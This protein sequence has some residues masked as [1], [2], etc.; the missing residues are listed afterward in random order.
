MYETVEGTFQWMNQIPKGNLLEF[1]VFSGNTMN[2]LIKGAE[3]SGQ[4]FEAVYGF[5]SW[6]GLP[7]ETEGVWQNP[8]WP[9]GAFN[10]CH[11]FNLKSTEEAL[12]FVQGRVERK[13]I[14]LVSGFF[15]DTLN[16]GWGNSLKESCSY[17]HVDVDI[18]ASTLQVLDFIFKYNILKSGALIRYD[19]W[20]STPEYQGGN[21]L[22]HLQAELKYG[23][24]FNRLGMNVFQYIKQCPYRLLG[25][26]I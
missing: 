5:D 17:L 25:H 12:V 20:M 21:S 9:A 13:D 8:E 23:V 11:D 1:G 4:P 18:H 10:V 19:D 7:K 14:V 3:A 6:V 24:Q 15:T 16:E 2:R 22:A 26:N